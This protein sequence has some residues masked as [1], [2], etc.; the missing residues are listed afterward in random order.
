MKLPFRLDGSLFALY[1]GVYIVF[2]LAASYLG[3]VFGYVSRFLSMLLFLDLFHLFWS[4]R[5]I[6]YSQN[7]STTHPVKGQNVEYIF[8][9]RLE[10]PIP[11]ARL[12][13][14]FKGIRQDLR[15]DYGVKTLDFFPGAGAFD[16]H[17]KQIQC[18]FRGTYTVGLDS[19]E[20]QDTLAM[21][22][23]KVPV[24]FITFYVY[25][26]LIELDSCCL[27]GEGKH[28]L[29]TSLAEG[30]IV[31]PTRF[32]SLAEYRPGESVRHLAWK[33]FAATGIPFL[34]EWERSAVP[35]IT[36]YLD[37]LR[38]GEPDHQSLLAE[39]C[40]LEILL[41]VSHWFVSHDIPVYVRNDGGIAR[42]EGG[43]EGFSR[44]MTDTAKLSFTPSNEAGL[45]SLIEGL[46][47][48]ISKGSL[49]TVAVAGIFRSFDREVVSFLES[50]SDEYRHC[51]AIVV[52][53]ALASGDYGKARE[54]RASS[55][56]GG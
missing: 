47:S 34:R 40:A 45:P 11:G 1:L 31:D 32:R 13:V 20:L 55:P 9:L 36:F 42:L 54:Y 43:I 27:V 8:R 37:T 6:R 51:Y 52:G 17:R 46:E 23:I 3:G 22:W 14:T 56:Y 35:G 29:P 19:M 30:A 21:L 2:H 33:K 16:E 48:D 4:F 15:L 26:R 44:F 12:M 53:S 24:W 18:P 5:R 49:G 39:D 25:P 28:D 41:A 7:F 50:Y 10:S 38:R